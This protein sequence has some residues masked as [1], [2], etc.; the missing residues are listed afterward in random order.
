MAVALL[1]DP[2]WDLVEP[3]LADSSP[4][5]QRRTASHFGSIEPSAGASVI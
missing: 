2:L 3:V 5:T 1:S 4:S